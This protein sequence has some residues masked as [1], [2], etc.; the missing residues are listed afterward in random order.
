M[1]Y[2]FEAERQQHIEEYGSFLYCPKHGNLCCYM[3]NVWETGEG[4]GR[5][6][7]IAEDPEYQKLQEQQQAYQQGYGQPQGYPQQQGYQSR[8][9]DND[10]DNFINL[11]EGGIDEELPFH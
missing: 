8:G 1:T 7:C 11:P 3:E 2:R 4:C 6:P 5:T 10:V 9:V